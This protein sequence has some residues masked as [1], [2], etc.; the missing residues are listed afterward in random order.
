[1]LAGEARLQLTGPGHG[2]A[3]LA[4]SRDGLPRGGRLQLEY[5]T[6]TVR[7]DISQLRWSTTGIEWGLQLAGQGLYAG[8]LTSPSA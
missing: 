1:M 3:K 8:R 6:D 2:I 7:L 4:W 5:N